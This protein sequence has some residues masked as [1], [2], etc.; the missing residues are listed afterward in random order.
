MTYETIEPIGDRRMGLPI[1][2]WAGP[3]DAAAMQQAENLSLLPVARGHIALMPDAHGGYGMPI[4]G[5]LFTQRAV[6]PYA[7]GVDIGCGVILV[8]LGIKAESLIAEDRFPLVLKQTKDHVPTGFETHKTAYR[9]P[10]ALD[11]MEVQDLPVGV[12]K[13]WFEKALPQLGTL[14]G[15]NHFIEFQ[16]DEDGNA[17]LM[18]HSGS[19]SLGK[20]I[21]DFY[22]KAALEE[23][24]RWHSI[25]PDPELAFL[26]QGSDLFTLYMQAMDFALTYAE[27]NRRLMLEKAIN[28]V[29]TW[30]PEF[31]EATVVADCHHNYAAW[32]N[33]LD[34]HG[35]VH[36]KG[37]VRARA[38]ELVLIPGSMGTASYLAEGLGNRESFNTCQHGAGRA[39]TR[40]A[41]RR[42]MTTEDVVKDMNE[43]GVAVVSPDM[44]HIM[45]EAPSAYK[46]I[47]AVMERSA[48]LVRPIKRLTP[49]GVVKG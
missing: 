48:D 9:L 29:A 35:I 33:H 49:L 21:C 30:V 27:T 28:A 23:N 12:K 14:G 31:S 19:R 32:E 8:D 41:M 4:G 42:S 25:L 7:I 26:P 37:A 24:R 34:I 44:G 39:Q 16:Q 36:R 17:F 43:R 47:E 46:D 18:L 38:G 40:G 10:V 6:V 13:E 5:V 45:E 1:K 3:I 11:L 15:G 22:H 2:S 20:N